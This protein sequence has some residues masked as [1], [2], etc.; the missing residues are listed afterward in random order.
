MTDEEVANLLRSSAPIVVIEAP[1][2]CGKTHQAASYAADVGASLKSGRLLVLTHTHAACSVIAK[3]TQEY[4]NKIDIRTLDSLIN[5]VAT[6]YRLSL[7]LPEDVSA[8][9]RQYGYEM[10]ATKVSNLLRSNP[11]IAKHLTKSF[12]VIICDEHQDSNEAQDQIVKLLAKQGALLRVFGDPMQIIPGGI[13]HNTVAAATLERWNFLKND[14]EFGELK[15]PHRWKDTNYDLGTWILGA[16]ESLKNG[17]ALNLKEHLPVGVNVQF[18]E[19]NSPTPASYQLAP[20]SW[21]N[22]NALLNEDK[23][24]LLVAGSNPTIQSLR[25][26]FRPRF[27]IWEGH[28]RNNLENFIEALKVNEDNLTNRTSAFVEC[29]KGLLVGFSA[30]R[31]GNRLI[32]EVQTPTNKPRGKI[33]P[34]LKAMAEFIREE[35]SHIGFSR[36]AEYLKEL[37]IQNADGFSEINI[38]YQRELDDLIKLKGH[39]DPSLGFAE[40]AKRRSRSY[41]RPPRKALSTI[42]KSK[43]LEA[44][45]I[46]V[47]A[48]DGMHFGETQVKRN[49]LYVALSRATESVT[50]IVSRKNRSPLVEV[51]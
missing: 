18:A 3:R 24:M 6:A 45:H 23:E 14:S 34:R 33:P 51:S 32:Q 9:A 50:I 48:C 21:H 15:T 4:H 13:G 43:G 8:W 19:N 44:E 7:E 36:A 49:L 35:P 46:F 17:H 11:I 1:A 12:P 27:P 31:Y 20:E 41:P 22:L 38:D 25:G 26:S 42:H 30:N 5:Q 16:R 37:I 47:F 10:L 39:D 40:I 2:G 28:T 29:L